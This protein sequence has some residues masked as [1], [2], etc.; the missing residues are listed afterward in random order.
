M[1]QRSDAEHDDE[2]RDR[3]G[4]RTHTGE[5][6]DAGWRGRRA[7]V[8]RVVAVLLDELPGER[9]RIDAR[10]N[11]EH[12]R[13][14]VELIGDLRIR[15]KPRPVVTGA[16]REVAHV[17]LREQRDPDDAHL[18]RRDCRICGDA[19]FV[20][21]ADVEIAG[22]VRTEHDLVLGS[23]LASGSQG[24]GEVP[25]HRRES[26]RAYG[27]AVDVR[28]SGIPPCDLVEPRIGR[29]FVGSRLDVARREVELHL[30]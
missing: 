29:E 11:A 13:R 27:R 21:D 26:P 4:E 20:A 19:D 15:T 14:R 30:P 9:I 23:R 1:C 28:E 17:D 12:D 18:L 22:C 5:I 2:D 10:R 6:A 24:V 3:A 16:V 7:H 8:R 25:A